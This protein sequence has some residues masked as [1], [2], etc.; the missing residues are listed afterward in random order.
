[1]FIAPSLLGMHNESRRRLEEQRPRYL[2]V[3]VTPHEPVRSIA[4]PK[5]D[6]DPLRNI[7]AAACNGPPSLDLL[8][9]S[10]Q[11]EGRTECCRPYC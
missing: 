1:M 11:I 9:P 10:T 2:R 4:R 8:A 5:V 7:A 6:S 3:P